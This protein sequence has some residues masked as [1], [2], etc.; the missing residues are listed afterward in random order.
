[1]ASLRLISLLALAIAASA[2]AG[3]DCKETK[4]ESVE[5]KVSEVRELC[6]LQNDE[7][8]FMTSD[9]V[10]LSCKV[11]Q[12]LKSKSVPHS[13]TE[14]PGALFCKSLGGVVEE[15]RLQGGKLKIQR[16]L[17][18]QEKSSLSLNLLESWNGKHFSGPSKPLDL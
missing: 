1:M 11:V 16:C 7:T 18:T 5:L 15:V 3:P 6:F 8:Y 10:D 4:I 12:K 2:W 14:R 13:E 17:F 9:C